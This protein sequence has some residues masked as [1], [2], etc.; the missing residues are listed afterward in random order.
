MQL[1]VGRIFSC[2]KWFECSE[3][4]VRMSSASGGHGHGDG[5]GNGRATVMH[6]A[7]DDGTEDSDSVGADIYYGP[8][9]IAE[10]G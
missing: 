7:L 10:L 2:P 5:H 1:F 6:F 9:F 3:L 4:A 8:E